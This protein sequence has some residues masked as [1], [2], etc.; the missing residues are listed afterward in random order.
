MKRLT[1]LLLA[2]LFIFGAYSGVKAQSAGTIWIETNQTTFSAGDTIT[3]TLKA[4]SAAP[5]QGLTFQLRYDP[6]CLQPGTP[7]SLLSGLN[8]LSVENSARSPSPMTLKTRP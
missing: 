5:I 3:V 6:A 4:N 1:T 2:A 7:T 8:P